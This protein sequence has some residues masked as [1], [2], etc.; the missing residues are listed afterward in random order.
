MFSEVYLGPTAE[1]CIFFQTFFF[2]AQLH[3]MLLHSP[4]KVFELILKQRE[5]PLQKAAPC[6]CSESCQE[7]SIEFATRKL[8]FWACGF[9]VVHGGDVFVFIKYSCSGIHI[10]CNSVVL[11]S[12]LQLKEWLND[13]PASLLS[14]HRT[15]F[16]NEPGA[17]FF[18][19]YIDL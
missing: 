6:F 7:F 1:L 19:V 12:L 16:Q 17:T 11:Q 9:F 8:L 4:K 15:G 14:N 13:E 10:P 3:F 5:R 2:I 18:P